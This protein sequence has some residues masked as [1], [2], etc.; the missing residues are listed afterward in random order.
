MYLSR[1]QAQAGGLKVCLSF[2]LTMF[3]AF[4]ISAASQTDTLFYINGSAGKLAAKMSLPKLAPGEKCPMVILSHG[5]GMNMDYGLWLPLTEALNAKGVGTVRFDFNGHGKSEGLFQD[6]TVPNE[7]EDLLAVIAWVSKQA[8]TA[9]ISLVG[10]SQGGVVTS[11]VAG[12]CGSGQIHCEV[13]LSAAAVLREDAL[14]D[15]TMGT[16][17]NPWN[18]DKEWYDMP[19]G[20]QRLGREY[21][22]TAMS[23]PIYETAALFT[24]PALIVNGMRDTVVPYT[25]AQLYHEVLKNSELALLPDEDHVYSVCPQYLV[26]LVADWITKFVK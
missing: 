11:M 6:M 7:I 8:I 9:N 26:K 10:H 5:F 17:Y 19:W 18:L 24:G 20:G 16:L 23:L 4:T 25:Y 22:R 1:F 12:Q 14:K 3:T 13:L 15:N 21:I 2:L